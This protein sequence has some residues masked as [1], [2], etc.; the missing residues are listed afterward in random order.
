MPPSYLRV[1]SLSSAKQRIIFACRGWQ[2]R[3]VV[4]VCSCGPLAEGWKGGRKGAQ[5]AAGRRRRGGR[6]GWP[7]AP[8]SSAP[9][10]LPPTRRCWQTNWLHPAKP[11]SSLPSPSPRL[12]L[13]LACCA[14]ALHGRRG[15]DWCSVAR[16]THCLRT[17]SHARSARVSGTG[18]KGATACAVRAPARACAASSLCGCT[19]AFVFGLDAHSGLGQPRRHLRRVRVQQL[20][21]GGG[22]AAPGAGAGRAVCGSLLTTDL[23][24]A[25]AVASSR[26]LGGGPRPG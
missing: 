11:F 13:R 26:W 14:R 1:L 6:R 9:P 8:S 5:A 10:A 7:P 4:L 15:A 17:L 2:D 19:G 3:A 23:L 22:D 20:A 18:Q 25:P 16:A 21:P 12:C 24:V